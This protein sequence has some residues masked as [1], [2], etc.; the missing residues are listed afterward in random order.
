[1]PPTAAPS[2]S[3]SSKKP[4]TLFNELWKE[5]EDGKTKAPSKSGKSKKCKKHGKSHKPTNVVETDA[6]ETVAEVETVWFDIPAPVAVR[7]HIDHVFIFSVAKINCVSHIEYPSSL[8]T[9][10][11][12]TQINQLL[13]GTLFL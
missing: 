1:M 7:Q 11:L 12:S 2:K 8:L 9:N 10:R 6:K 13:M 4:Y 3:K 5:C